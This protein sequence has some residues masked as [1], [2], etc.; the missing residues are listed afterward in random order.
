LQPHYLALHGLSKLLETVSLVARRIN[1]PLRVTGVIVC[2]HEAGTR[3]ASEVLED[4]GSFLNASEQGNNPWAGAR[5]FKTLIRRNIKLAECPSHGMTIFDYAPQSHGSEDYA[6]LAVEVRAMTEPDA[7]GPPTAS[8]ARPRP[9]KTAPAP[10][11]GACD[12]AGDSVEPAIGPKPVCPSAKPAP[13]SPRRKRKAPAPAR[14]S[15]EPNQEAV[16]L[17]AP[18]VAIE[19]SSAPSAPPLSQ[20][21]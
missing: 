21:G 12:S 4:V 6:A 5:V 11:A 3:L 16:T 8:P 2:M 17:A 9:A 20:T 15:V 7:A 1:P 18:V 14:L 10:S 19:A 13:V